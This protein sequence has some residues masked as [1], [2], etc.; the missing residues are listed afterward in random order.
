MLTNGLRIL[1]FSQ[2]IAILNLPLGRDNE[3][4]KY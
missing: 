3:H 4:T 1:I 2:K